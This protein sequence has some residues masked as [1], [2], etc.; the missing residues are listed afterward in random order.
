ME[1][2]KKNAEKL[3]VIAPERI[4]YEFLKV[5]KCP[6]SVTFFSLLIDAGYAP[7]LFKA[8]VDED[9]LGLSLEILSGIE[10][11][12]LS[13]HSYLPGVKDH[14][15]DE[16]E[17]G[18]TR[19]G[20]LRLAGF[21]AGIAGQEQ[22]N[23]SE[24]LVHSWCARLAL[25]SL[26]GRVIAKTITGMLQVLGPDEKPFLSGSGM[27]RLLSSYREC[28][29]EILFLALTSNALTGQRITDG[30]S[31]VSIQARVASLWGYFQGTYQAHVASPLLTG[32]DI[33]ENLSIDPGP[34]VGKLL[35]LVEEARADGIISS[36]GQALDYLRTIIAE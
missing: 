13:V 31:D 15:A 27:H 22:Q 23:N 29:P 18:L 1:V 34:N 20:A 10:R 14:F 4:K 17:H 24:D 12:L 9:R 16:L 11:L 21:F 8:P 5:L 6:A 36:R 30:T 35:R 28:I 32:H 33:M 19:S 3:Q 26:A 25:S 7:V 2:I